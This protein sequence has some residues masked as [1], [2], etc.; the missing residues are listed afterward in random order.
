MMLVRRGFLQFRYK[1]L[2]VLDSGFSLELH[3]AK[4]SDL[5][6]QGLN[7]VQMIVVLAK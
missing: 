3:R 6:S 2:L 1:G 7:I 4:P 5:W